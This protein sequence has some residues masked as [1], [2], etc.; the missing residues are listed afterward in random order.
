MACKSKKE[1]KL[2]D[3]GRKVLETL[4]SMEGPATGKQVATA[5]GLDSKLVSARIKTLRTKGFIDSPVRCKYTVTDLGR[6]H[7][8]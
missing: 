3:E 6:K 2:D 1:W 5:A 7:I 4:A 8:G